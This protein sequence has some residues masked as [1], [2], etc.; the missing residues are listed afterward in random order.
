V[1]DVLTNVTRAEESELL[2]RLEDGL[3]IRQAIAEKARR[4]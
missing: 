4:T 3:Q 1:G 2:G